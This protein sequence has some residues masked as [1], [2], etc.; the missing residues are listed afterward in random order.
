MIS[1]KIEPFSFFLS[2]FRIIECQLNTDRDIFLCFLSSSLL[3]RGAFGE[4]FRGILLGRE[5]NGNNTDIAVK[6]LKLQWLLF[7]NF[8]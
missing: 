1:R 6:V 5:R 4:V 2:I 8:F 3:G 7:F